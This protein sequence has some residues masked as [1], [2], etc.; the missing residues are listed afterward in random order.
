VLPYAISGVPLK[1]VFHLP[2]FL[3]KPFDNSLSNPSSQLMSC[4]RRGSRVGD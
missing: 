4:R 3:G 1:P 2:G